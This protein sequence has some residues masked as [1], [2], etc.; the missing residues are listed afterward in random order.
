MQ[1]CAPSC[2]LF[3]RAQATRAR[4]QLQQMSLPRVKLVNSQNKHAAG[5]L[6]MQSR[7]CNLVSGPLHTQ[8]CVTT[9]YIKGYAVN[10]G[11]ACRPSHLAPCR[12]R[13]GQGHSYSTVVHATGS[14]EETKTNTGA[15][16]PHQETGSSLRRRVSTHCQCLLRQTCVFGFVQADM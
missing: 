12:L 16:G 7:P 6:L 13:C 8:L 1:L 5:Q 11:A 2:L 4:I 3:M 14:C 10:Y 15:S 9:Q